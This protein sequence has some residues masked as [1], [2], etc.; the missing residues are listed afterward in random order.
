MDSLEIH[1]LGKTLSSEFLEEG[2]SLTEGL[3]KVASESG[4]NNNQVQRVAES[5]NVE[6]YLSLL[7]TNNGGYIDFDLARP[8]RVKTAS[9]DTEEVLGFTG[10]HDTGREDEEWIAELFPVETEKTA[11][12]IKWDPAEENRKNRV[13]LR[14]EIEFVEN[15]LQEG[16]QDVE[17][18]FN[19]LAHIIDQYKKSGEVPADHLTTVVKNAAP[20]SSQIILAGCH[21]PSEENLEKRAS[22]AKDTELWKTAHQLDQKIIGVAQLNEILEPLKKVAKEKIDEAPPEDK[23]FLKQASKT[24]KPFTDTGSVV[25]KF[26]KEHPFLTGASIGIPL[27]W[28]GKSA[29]RSGSES[30]IKDETINIGTKPKQYYPYG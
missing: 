11:E 14:G 26:I 1:K 22:V 8:E 15:N 17:G 13:H 27:Y 18:T 30:L 6:T 20:N 2:V 29:G 25:M 16:L 23:K 10:R 21:L 9:V 28:A 24:L 4:L 3:Q 19:K 7:K 12:E 5:A